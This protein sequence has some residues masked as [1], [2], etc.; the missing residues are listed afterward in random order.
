MCNTNANDLGLT[1]VSCA[2]GT[3]AHGPAT[4]PTGDAA[5]LTST[6]EVSG[7]T[8]GH[9]VSSVTEGVSRVGGVSTSR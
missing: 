2:C 7:L 3:H 5:P 4:A 8:C 9:C 6:F 1:D